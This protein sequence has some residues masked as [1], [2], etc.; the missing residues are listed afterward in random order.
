[1]ATKARKRLMSAGKSPPTPEP[2]RRNHHYSFAGATPRFSDRGVLL[3]ECAIID[4]KDGIVIN[5][6]MYQ[7]SPFKGVACPERM[8]NN[9]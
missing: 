3:T 4:F 8:R 9:G 2:T 6:S 1:M 5:F 7:A